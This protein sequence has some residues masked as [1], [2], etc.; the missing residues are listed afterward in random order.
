MVFFK[1]IGQD[2]SFSQLKN[3]TQVL[4]SEKLLEAQTG[5]AMFCLCKYVDLCLLKM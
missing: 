4:R 5:S 3:H 2:S 1:R